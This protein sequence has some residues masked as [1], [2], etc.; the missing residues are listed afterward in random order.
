MNARLDAALAYAARGWPVFPCRSGSKEPATAHGF[1][2][3]TTDPARLQHIWRRL[4][5]A[6]VAISTGGPGPDVLDVDISHG[7]TGYAALERARAAGLIPRPAGIVA[8]PSG[9]AHLY[10][11]G[12]GQRN[13]T[14]PGHGLDFRSTGGYVVAP[15]SM[16][17]GRSYAAIRQWQPDAALIDFAGIRGF[18]Q[19]PALALRGRPHRAQFRDPG[20]LAAWVAGQREGNRNQATFWAACRAAEAGDESAL[21]AIADAAVAAGLDRRAVEKTI[22]SAVRTATAQAGRSEREAAS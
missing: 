18:L 19:P 13:G 11:Q 9:G 10:Y 20:R 22:A 8:T 21:A 4:P 16:I 12:S 15:P 5:D 14:L 3:A 17:S 1:Y 2:D 7:R 6:N